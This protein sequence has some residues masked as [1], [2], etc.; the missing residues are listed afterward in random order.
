LIYS[1]HLYIISRKEPTSLAEERVSFVVTFLITPSPASIGIMD[2]MA[3]LFVVIAEVIVVRV[4]SVSIIY[5]RHIT[6]SVLGVT[7]SK[8]GVG[9]RTAG[10]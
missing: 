3:T 4:V 9:I 7:E 10:F 5:P 6:D 8:P 2:K 1:G